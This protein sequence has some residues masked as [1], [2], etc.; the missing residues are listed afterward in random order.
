MSDKNPA[1]KFKGK[2]HGIVCVHKLSSKVIGQVAD[3]ICGATLPLTRTMTEGRPGA[4]KT[5]DASRHAAVSHKQLGSVPIDD[6]L[7]KSAS[8]ALAEQAQADW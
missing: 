6:I 4:I 5:S 7:R 2:I 8:T 3:A 1:R